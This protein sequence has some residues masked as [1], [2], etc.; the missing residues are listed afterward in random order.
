MEVDD[1]SGGYADRTTNDWADLTIYY[2]DPEPT[3]PITT[4]S[5][6]SDYIGAVFTLIQNQRSEILFLL[7]R[8][9]KLVRLIQLQVRKVLIILQV[10]HIGRKILH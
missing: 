4:L 5:A 9:G 6:D 7:I 10:P 2:E 1:T 3:I 8:Y